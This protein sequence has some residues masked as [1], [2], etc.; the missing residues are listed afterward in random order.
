MESENEIQRLTQAY[1]KDM[2]VLPELRLSKRIFNF[3]FSHLHVSDGLHVS[4]NT[5]ILNECF[6]VLVCP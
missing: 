4:L 1:Q 3:S 6:A 2:E 5:I